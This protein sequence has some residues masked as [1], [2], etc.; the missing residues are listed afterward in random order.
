VGHKVARQLLEQGEHD[1]ILLA[2]DRNKLKAEMKQGAKVVQGDLADRAYVKKATK[3]VDTLFWVNPINYGTTDMSTW[4]RTLTEN[5]VEAIEANDITRTVFL[6]S[7]GAHME[8]G[9]GPINALH[10]CEQMFREAVDNLTILRPTYFMENFLSSLRTIGRDHNISLPVDG[11]AR[12]A[13]I[14]ADD[15]ARAAVDTLNEEFSGQSIRP[16][17]GPR[18]YTFGEAAEIIGSAIGE[19][20]DYVRVTP[21]QAIQS[22]TGMGMSNHVADLMSE[23]YNAID[24][25]RMKPEFPRSSQSTTP[26]TLED[27]ARTV[28][29]GAY[30]TQR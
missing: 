30:R 24:T 27:F 13:M 7:L 12:I 21:E 6:S 4:Y 18:E 17:H 15:V 26:T 3:G 14:A 1:V 16:L 25:G 19:R 9:M 8:Q 10:E 11:N 23:L 22:M 20:L 28:L 5:A 29:A 2:R